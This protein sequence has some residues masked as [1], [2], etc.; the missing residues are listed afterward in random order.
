MKN[1]LG[2]CK[3]KENL[4]GKIFIVTG[5]SDGLGYE[6]T[7]GLLQRGA[8]VIM[9]C[10]NVQKA[11]EA[12]KKIRQKI[13][14]GEIVILPLD[15]CSF[16]S[17]K[18]FSAIICEKYPNFHCLINNAGVASREKLTTEQNFEINVGKIICLL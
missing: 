11:S 14:E 4:E 8:K 18:E 7:L 15:L 16:D 6:T 5:A 10:R 3:N 17:I 9:A 12:V 13:S 1:K 2:W